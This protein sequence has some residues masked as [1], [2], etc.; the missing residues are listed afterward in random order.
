[1]RRWDAGGQS[2]WDAEWSLEIVVRSSKN[3]IDDTV[4][5]LVVGHW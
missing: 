1:M 2:R 4:Q 5:E 3:G